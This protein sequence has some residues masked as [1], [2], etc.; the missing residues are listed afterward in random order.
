MGFDPAL[1]GIAAC[2][3]AAIKAFHLIQ[4]A[5]EINDPLGAG[6]LMQPVDILCDYSTEQ[7]R[8]FEFYQ[9][10][11]AFIWLG[12]ADARPAQRRPTPVA[13]PFRRVRDKFVV[14]NRLA[15][16]PCSLVVTIGG[17]A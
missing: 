2:D 9:S 8:L 16:Q 10:S 17:Y 6:T 5:V 3:V 4:S 13:L 15:A 11:V 1:N 14:L 7:A 12:C